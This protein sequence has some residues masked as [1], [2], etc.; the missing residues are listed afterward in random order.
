MDSDAET[1]TKHPFHFDASAAFLFICIT[2]I[3]GDKMLQSR[4]RFEQSSGKLG[5]KL[6]HTIMQ[7]CRRQGICFRKDRIAISETDL[8]LGKIRD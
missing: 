2:V 4:I 3:Q 5:D 6:L 8:S 7:V 1:Y